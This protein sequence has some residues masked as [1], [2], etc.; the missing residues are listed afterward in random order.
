MERFL[1]E[2]QR[3]RDE[4]GQDEQDS[5]G[6]KVGQ[7]V[8]LAVNPS[9][10][11]IKLPGPRP[12]RQKRAA[13]SND[14]RKRMVA[15]TIQRHAMEACPECRTRLHGESVGWTR[16]V[17]DIPE[18][19]PV[20]VTEHQVIKRRCMRCDRWH[21][22]ALELGSA[23]VGHSRFGI[24]LVS[25][26]SWRRT[27]LRLPISKIKTYLTE[28][29]A[30]RTRAGEIVALLK[31]TAAAGDAEVAK[32]KH[33]ICNERAVYADE[34][35]WREDGNNRYVW[36]ASTKNGLRLYQFSASRAS[37]MAEKLLPHCAGTVIFDFYGAYNFIASNRQRCWA[38]L[39]RDHRDL[40]QEFSKYCPE[41]ITWL[42]ALD[43]L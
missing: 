17:I 36:V 20:V 23:V 16:E 11:H 39:K 26:V 43:R 10:R 29:H 33:L 35:G 9:V 12:L 21:L 6:G 15:T 8:K 13:E 42:A 30:L 2:N 19:L 37:A 31:R 27:E 18:T 14:G 32:I 40:G 4:L 24:N 28:R 41:I 34:T 22:P 7:G 25:L 1:V 3:L 5:P 38:H